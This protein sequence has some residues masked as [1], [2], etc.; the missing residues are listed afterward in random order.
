M[1]EQIEQQ[2]DD[3]LL[4]VKQIDREGFGDVI[5]LLREARNRVVIRMGG[6][7]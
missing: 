3:A 4:L 6:V 1:L 7:E 2:I 5:R